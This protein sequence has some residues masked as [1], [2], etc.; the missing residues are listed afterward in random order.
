MSTLTAPPV[1][2]VFAAFAAIDWAS[3]E[4][5]VASVPAAGGSA[6]PAAGRQQK[7]SDSYSAAIAKYVA[8][9]TD[10]AFE[11]LAD[12]PALEPPLPLE[13]GM[14]H[15]DA[16]I[17]RFALQAFTARHQRLPD[18]AAVQVLLRDADVGI[19]LE[20][21]NLARELPGGEQAL[22]ELGKDPDAYVR[23]MANV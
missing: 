13:A 18:E 19:R 10:A 15:P 2:P 9:D 11:A 6:T 21:V 5:V 7:P 20:L 14:A 17:R 8:G 3:K 23:A 16:R 4:H 22:R 1:E 12:V